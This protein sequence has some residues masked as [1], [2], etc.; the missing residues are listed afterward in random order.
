MALAHMVVVVGVRA[1]QHPE[2]VLAPVTHH[3]FLVPA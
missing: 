2:I 1:E 3:Q